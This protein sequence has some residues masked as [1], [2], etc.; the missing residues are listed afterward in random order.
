MQP[1]SSFT[2]R[3]SK[4]LPNLN[5]GDSNSNNNM[6]FKKEDLPNPTFKKVLSEAD[7]SSQ[8]DSSPKV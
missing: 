6:N 2:N 8:Q 1:Q 3:S 5:K 7:S 4:R